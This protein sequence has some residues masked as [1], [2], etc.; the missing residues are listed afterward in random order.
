M[1]VLRKSLG[2]RVPW[3][4]LA[5]VLDIPLASAALPAVAD[6]PV[7][8]GGGSLHVYEDNIKG[9]GWHH[10]FACGSQGDLVELA[11]AAWEL[12]V[13]VTLVKLAQEGIPLSPDDLRP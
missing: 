12:P 9:G 13:D 2:V 10:C 5:A 3:P 7:C 1:M 11:A 4:E 8:H 6:C